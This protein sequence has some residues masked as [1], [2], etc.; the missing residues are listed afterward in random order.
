MTSL[1]E[2]N[3]DCFSHFSFSEVTLG[4][5]NFV[6]KQSSQIRGYDGVPQSVFYA[7]FSAM[8]KNLSKSIYMSMRESIFLSI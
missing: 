6:L 1:R 5:I 3:E 7:A 8:G 2:F 4:D